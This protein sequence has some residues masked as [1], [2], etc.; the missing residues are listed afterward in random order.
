MSFFVLYKGGL[1][2]IYILNISQA[3]EV[4]PRGGSFSV[5]VFLSL[6]LCLLFSLSFVALSLLSPCPGILASFMPFFFV[7]LIS[8][9]SLSSF[10]SLDLLCQFPFPSRALFLFRFY[11]F[12]CRPEN[13]SSWWRQDAAQPQVWASGSVWSAANVCVFFVVCLAIYA[14]V[15]ARKKE[16]ERAPWTRAGRAHIGWSGSKRPKIMYSFFF[17]LYPGPGF[18]F[19]GMICGR[20]DILFSSFPLAKCGNI[21]CDN[22]LLG[23][24][25]LFSLLSK[26]KIYFIKLLRR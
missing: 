6:T 22:G 16:K 1:D 13:M 14:T 9:K 19:G 12:F 24:R 5:S 7:Q 23:L 18:R 2:P 4:F 8:L 11:L 25:A 3:H 26:F 21:V 10:S 15:M 17:I 20:V